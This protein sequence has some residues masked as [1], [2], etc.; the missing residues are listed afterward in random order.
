MNNSEQQNI[1]IHKQNQSNK[2]F[3]KDIH[4]NNTPTNTTTNF[5]KDNI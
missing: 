1:L 3:K 5:K 2:G 4:I